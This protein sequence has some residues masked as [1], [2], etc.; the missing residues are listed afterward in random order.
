MKILA[1]N[2]VPFRSQHLTGSRRAIM[3]SEHARELLNSRQLKLVEKLF[4]P[5]EPKDIKAKE[6]ESLFKKLGG[7]VKEGDGSRI[8]ISYQ[9]RRLFLHRPHKPS[10]LDPAAVNDIKDFLIITKVWEDEQ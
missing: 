6:V 4:K 3:I 2:A 8:R 9:G 1:Q 10:V 5:T 7:F